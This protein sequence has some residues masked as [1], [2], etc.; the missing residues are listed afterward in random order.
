MTKAWQRQKAQDQGRG[1][2]FQGKPP[3]H[4]IGARTQYAVNI[5][6]ENFEVNLL[7]QNRKFTLYQSCLPGG[8]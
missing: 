2:T 5:V 8:Q 3:G 7:K 4:N 6:L 1:L